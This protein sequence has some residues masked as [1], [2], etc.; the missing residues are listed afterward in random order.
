MPELYQVILLFFAVFGAAFG[1][2]CLI[3]SGERYFEERKNEPQK[4]RIPESDSRPTEQSDPKI[5]YI[6]KSESIPKPKK[7][8]RKTRKKP[9]LAFKSIKGIVI[10]P[11]EFCKKRYD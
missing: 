8:T 5:Y 9:D 7:R 4:R 1:F 3:R 2:A 10:Q 6:R 11:E